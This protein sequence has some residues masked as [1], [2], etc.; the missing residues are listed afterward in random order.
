[1]TYKSG[2]SSWTRTGCGTGRV[3]TADTGPSPVTDVSVSRDGA[4]AVFNATR[5]GAKQIWMKDL[6]SG[7]EK[8]L[9]WGDGAG[10]RRISADGNH[11]AWQT[12]EGMYALSLDTRGRTGAE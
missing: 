2:A 10:N 11:V 8:Q 9:T 4:R 12:R 6:R 5:S 3:Q 1:M 7:A